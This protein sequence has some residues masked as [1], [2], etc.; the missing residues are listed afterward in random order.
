MTSSAMPIDRNVQKSSENDR[1]V[2]QKSSTKLSVHSIKVQ[3]KVLNGEVHYNQYFP[4]E[5]SALL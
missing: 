4:L 5:T 1:K 3:N 2:E